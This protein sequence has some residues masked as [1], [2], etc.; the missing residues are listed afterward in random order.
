MYEYDIRA[1]KEAGIIVEEHRLRGGTA[2]A[3]LIPC[4]RCKRYITRAKVD[5]KRTYVCDVCKQNERNRMK[6]QLADKIPR[7]VYQ[8]E[9]P[10]PDKHTKRF[11]K[12]KEAILKYGYRK[13]DYSRAL[14]LI[15]KRRYEMDSIPEAMVAIQLL[16]DKHKVV[17]HPKV[18]GYKP[19]FAITD[20]KCIVEVDGGLYHAD[21][22]K[23]ER[24]DYALR[25]SMGDEWAIVHIPAE[26]IRKNIWRLNYL[27]KTAIKTQVRQGHCRNEMWE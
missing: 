11:L 26:Y 18:G 15:E 13:A 5:F 4:S 27:I 1:L 6:R 25:Y 24:R 16:Q 20:W 2:P 8:A 9:I 12:A 3:Y 17:S 7:P 14:D 10:N 19:D 21:I 23:Q 22:D